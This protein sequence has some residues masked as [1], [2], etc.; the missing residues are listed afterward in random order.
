M[1]L[2]G[3]S[4]FDTRRRARRFAMIPALLF[5][6]AC[7]HYAVINSGLSPEEAARFVL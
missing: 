2:E 6:S 1:E 4:M 7:D 3:N 5:L